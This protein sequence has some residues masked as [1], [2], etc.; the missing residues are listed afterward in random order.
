MSTPEAGPSKGQI[1][2]AVIRIGARGAHFQSHNL[3]EALNVETGSKQ[4]ARAHAML[5]SLVRKG[6]V[7]ASEG[8]LRNRYYVLK[9][10]AA[11]RAIGR[12][13]GKHGPRPNGNPG[14][15]SGFAERL[16]A[17][18]ATQTHL[19]DAIE[20]LQDSVDKLTELWS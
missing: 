1:H 17:I 12:K 19:V 15:G 3:R 11:V 9:D 6:Y 2:R 4:A 7:E 16:K 14:I 13:A 5:M 20:A 10:A 18:E 8:R